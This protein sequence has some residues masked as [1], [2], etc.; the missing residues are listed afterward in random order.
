MNLL[1][2]IKNLIEDIENSHSKNISYLR[3][4]ELVKLILLNLPILDNDTI[5]S[6]AKEDMLSDIF[7]EY[8]ESSKIILDFFSKNLSFMEDDLK[9]SDFE[10]ELVKNVRD[11][12]LL[13][14]EVIKKR[15]DYIKLKELENDKKDIMNQILELESS[16]KEFNKID[17]E[18]I[19]SQKEKLENQLNYLIETEGENLVRY[20]KHLEEN[21]F[22][23]IKTEELNFI[24]S[25][26]SE[27]LIEMDDLY[28]N[29]LDKRK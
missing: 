28:K 3:Q 20:K 29:I 6:M 17:L 26:I 13:K 11:I 9:D 23:N 2:Q 27:K 16:I 22:I 10:K 12:D 18:Q 7:Y 4:T 5:N 21:D 15:E 8:N 14:Q 24:S 1:S 19:K 25:E